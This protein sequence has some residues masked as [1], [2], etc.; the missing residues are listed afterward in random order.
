MQ[1]VVLKRILAAIVTLLATIGFLANAAGLVGIWVARRP[2]RDTVTTLSTFVNNKLGTVH[3]AL[4]RVGARADQSRQ[5]LARINN[6]TRALGDR[7]D[8]GSPLLT[9]LVSATRD[10]L[11]PNIAEMRAQA[12]VLHDGVVSV[13]AAL[14]TLK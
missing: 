12:L 8:Q 3:Q 14:E 5:A 1:W 9:Q 2:A 7:L 4:A 10:G 11:G 13:N 6:A